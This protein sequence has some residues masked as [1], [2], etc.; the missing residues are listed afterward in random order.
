MSGGRCM[1]MAYILCRRYNMKEFGYCKVGSRESV[2]S[3]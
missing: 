1:Q 3:H 2:G